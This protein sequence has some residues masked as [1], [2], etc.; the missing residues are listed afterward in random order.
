LTI[1]AGDLLDVSQLGIYLVDPAINI[2]D[3]NNTSGG[4]GAL[5][6]DLDPNVPGVG[7]L[8][9]QTDTTAANF[10]GNY[11]LGLQDFFPSSGVP[12]PLSSGEVDFVGNAAVT[13]SLTGGGTISDPLFTL[14][15]SSSDTVSFTAPIT[16][17]ATNVGR[18]AIAP[19]TVTTSGAVP[20]AIPYSAN[21]Y[22][23]SGAQLFWIE[24][25]ADTLSSVF[26]GQLQQQGTIGVAAAKKKVK[27]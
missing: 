4:G 5:V 25:G 18:Y 22:Q 6:V 9:P 21:A 15:A 11:V 24:D 27:P 23:A 1:T 8:V 7:V 3:P 14:S 10:T 16:P 2:N 17:D 26:G 19:F 13:T 12:L 20:V